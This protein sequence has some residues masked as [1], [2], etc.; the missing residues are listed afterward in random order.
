MVRRICISGGGTGIGRQVALD[1]A[2]EGNDI[3]IIGR[4]SQPLSQ[5]RAECLQ[6]GAAGARAAIADLREPQSINELRDAAAEGPFDVVIAAAGGNSALSAGAP[7]LVGTD[8]ASWHWTANFQ[9]NVLTAV[10]LIEGLRELDAIAQGG[11]VILVSS[12]AAYR[13]SGS[14]SYAGTKAALHPYA[15]DLADALGTHGVTVNVV[16]PGYVAETEFFQGGMSPERHNTLIG[17]TLTGRAGLP[18]DVSATILWLCGE[19]A[20]HVTGQ[21]IQVNGGANLGR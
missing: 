13:G 7:D 16:A 21:I 19:S 9:T 3:T 20:R 2:A 8:W 6:A 4:R 5:V 17:Q 14:G 10:H 1:F 12:I 15:F 11:S 18:S